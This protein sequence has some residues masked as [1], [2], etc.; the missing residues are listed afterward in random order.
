MIGPGQNI[1]RKILVPELFIQLLYLRII[2]NVQRNF[3]VSF[4]QT[5]Q[6]GIQNI[7]D[8][9]FV[10]QFTEVII[11]ADFNHAVV[12]SKAKTRK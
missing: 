5:V 3:L 4:K 7:F 11:A 8:P 10:Y 9:C 2:G 12:L 6:K 1:R